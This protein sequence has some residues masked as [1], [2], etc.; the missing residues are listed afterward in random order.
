MASKQQKIKFGDSATTKKVRIP[1]DKDYTRDE[2]SAIA[3]DIIDYVVSRTKKRKD[4][5][6]NSMKGYTKEYAQTPEAKAAGKKAGQKA[7]LNLSGDML[8][9][10][11]EH[12]KI[13]STYV[14]IGYAKGSDDNDKADGNVRGTYGK[15]RG[16]SKKARD[17]MGINQT[18]LDKI[19][20]NYPIDDDEEKNK[21]V[22]IVAEAARLAAASLGN[23]DKDGK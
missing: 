1:L 3:Q 20:D 10:L 14:E 2:K 15:Q 6:G 17:F 8:F 16:S 13:G 19:L 12:M 4:R 9:S 5:F 7:N 22:G 18:E 21:S 23:K 11:G